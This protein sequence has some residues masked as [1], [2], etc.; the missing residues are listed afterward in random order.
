MKHNIFRKRVRRRGRKREAQN[1]TGK[2]GNEKEE[3]R[4]RG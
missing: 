3:E 1:S 2:A 4:E